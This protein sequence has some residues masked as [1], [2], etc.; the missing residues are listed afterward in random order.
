MLIGLYYYNKLMESHP[1]ETA[2]NLPKASR[3]LLRRSVHLSEPLQ[4]KV[5]CMWEKVMAA[6]DSKDRDGVTPYPLDG[7]YMNFIDYGRYLARVAT[8]PDVD[9]DT[10]KGLLIPTRNVSL[11]ATANKLM[12][13]TSFGGRHTGRRPARI[14]LAIKSQQLDAD[15]SK[16]RQRLTYGGFPKDGQYSERLNSRKI[17]LGELA[18]DVRFGQCLE[19]GSTVSK[20]LVRGGELELGPAEIIE[21]PMGVRL[22]RGE[23]GIDTRLTAE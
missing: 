2:Q 20:I 9:R 10:L 3:L 23:E 18:V 7:L 15:I 17:P 16:L 1:Q 6:T 21:P 13:R 19:L 12:S 8:T 14:S 11:G 4:E 5:A 22:P